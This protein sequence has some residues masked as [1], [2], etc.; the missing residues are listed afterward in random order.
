MT[1]HLFEGYGI[2]LEYMIADRDTLAVRPI[3]DLVLRQA[4]GND[5]GDFENGAAAW[6]NELVLHVLE[7]KTN[8]PAPDLAALP[9]LFAA[10]VKQ[11]N[12]MLAAHN[13]M[14]LPGPMHPFFDPMTETKLWPHSNNVVYETYN[15]IFDCRGHGWSNLQSTHLNLPFANDTEFARLH[16]AIRMILPILPALSAGSPVADGK[17]QDALDF[18]LVKYST[19]SARI[20]SATGKVVPEP[21]YT[22]EAYYREILQRIWNDTKPFDPD[23]N[24]EGEYANARG[25]IARFDR[26]A[27]E[28]RVLD[29]QEC[30]SADIAICAL[31]AQTLK[32]L[33]AGIAR[34]IDD[35]LPWPVD[36]LAA[37]FRQT[38]VSAENT[39]VT[40][41][42][43]LAALGVAGSKATAGEIWR[44]LAARV[45]PQDS[46]FAP[47]L[48]VILKQGSLASRLKRAL[49]AQPGQAQ[50]AATWQQLA[51]CL[52]E[53]RQFTP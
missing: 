39:Q 8:G 38:M 29:I 20:P 31:V 7:F 44:S 17:L 3:S 10:Q 40:D 26:M 50:I 11:V 53:N 52:A 9:A 14:L 46:P 18:R 51:A 33:I 48:D 45:M 36:P 6:S 37:M 34:P 25:A 16:A 32:A 2:E 19:N 22:K 1:L 24:L 15:R 23:G 43:Y 21:V 30:P 49:G 28:I 27:I 42:E 4:S 35:L 41:G 47:A 12:A 13:A 5:E